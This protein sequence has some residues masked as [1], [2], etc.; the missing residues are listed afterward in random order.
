ML[1]AATKSNIPCAV[2][3]S[4][5]VDV[6]AETDRDARPLRNV[7]CRECGLVWVDPRPTDEE[8]RQFYAEKYRSNYKG[9]AEPKK[10]HCY[11]EMLRANRRVSRVRE[12]Y[13]AGDRLLDVG[14]GA[15]FFSYVLAGSGVDYQGI[16]PNSGYAGFARERLG[17]DRVRV[18]YLEDV[19]DF[20]SYD[21]ITINHVFEHLPDPNAALSHMHRLL[22]DQGHVIMEVPSVL[23]DYHAPNKVFHVGHLYWYD[24][25]TLSAMALKHGFEV[26]DVQIVPVTAHVNMVMRKL[27]TPPAA[28]W[29][30]A[31]VGNY[32][33]VRRF[34][35]RR[36][37]FAH[38]LSTRPYSRFLRKMAGYLDEYRYVKRFEDKVRLIES[39]P[40][41]RI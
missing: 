18:G 12:F 15:G 22:R 37:M 10:K 20:G 25:E 19:E 1:P 39:V 40:R 6:V 31:Y 11:R 2:C 9:A 41:E 26:V 23:A 34:F 21:I 29:Q 3:G 7:L 16:E 38:Y 33:K 17:L 35:D 5:E 13:R 36:S 4:H 14:A 30:A 27:E 24:T 32:A 28:D 8:L